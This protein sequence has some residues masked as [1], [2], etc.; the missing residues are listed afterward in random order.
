MANWFVDTIIPTLLASFIMFAVG[1]FYRNNVA[2]VISKQRRAFLQIMPFTIGRD[3]K[4]TI[5]YGCVAP[6]GSSDAFLL[7]QG[8]FSAI[9]KAR[10][11]INNVFAISKQEFITSIDLSAQLLNYE[12]ILSISGPKWNAVTAKIMGELGCPVEFVSGKQMVKVT[13]KTTQKSVEYETK[14]KAGEL[15]TECYGII[16]SGSIDRPGHVKQNVLICAGRTTLSTYSTVSYLNYLRCSKKEVS[17]LM[18][19]G[20]KGDDKWCLLIRA[21]REQHTDENKNVP[22]HDTDI[23]FDIVQVFHQDD[24]LNPYTITYNKNIK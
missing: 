1:Y 12:N 5:T 8:D 16:L 23:V 20:I 18:K 7:Q 9:I 22:L 19:K 21:K 2:E 17:K 24:F 3:S 14:K 13:N 11:I 6:E 10:E 4:I 15:A